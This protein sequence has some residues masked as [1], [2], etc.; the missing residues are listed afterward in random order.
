M[1]KLRRIISIFLAALLLAAFC[2]PVY[3]APLLTSGDYEYYIKDD[4]TAELSGYTG[5]EKNITVP[6]QIEGIPVTSIGAFT[7]EGSQI[8]RV[9]VENGI[10]SI[11]EAFICPTA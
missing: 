11:S 3:A 10:Q 5:T 2:I 6:A 9:E 4:G 8:E 7:F 1:K